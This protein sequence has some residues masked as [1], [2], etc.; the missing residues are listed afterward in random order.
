M[1][2]ILGLF[3]ISVVI[4]VVGGLTWRIVEN[5]LERRQEEKTS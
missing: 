1:E 2:L 5:Y 3:G 4:G